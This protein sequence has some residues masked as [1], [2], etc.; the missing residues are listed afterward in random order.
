MNHSTKLLGPDDFFATHKFAEVLSP[1]VEPADDDTDR[2]L[3][4]QLHQLGFASERPSTVGKLQVLLA[5]FLMQATRLEGRKERK[6]EPMV[7]GIAHDE[8][9]W[10][11]RSS[12]GY[13][14][15]LRFREAL[16]EHA[17]IKHH[18]GATVNLFEGEGNCTGYLIADHVPAIA[19]GLHFQTTDKV[20]ATSTSSSNK[21]IEVEAV[22]ER[23]KALWAKWKHTPLM[24]G[25]QSMFIAPRRFNN[26]AL[27]RGGRFYGPWTSMRK[28][29]RLECTLDGKQV[30]EVDVSGMHLTLLCSIT[31]EIPFATRFKDAYECG[32]ENR[33]HV[34]AIINET[35]GAGTP[36]HY[37]IGGLAKASGLTQEQFTHIRKTFI[38]PKFRC[39]QGL[40]KGVLDGLALAYHESEIMLRVVEQSNLPIYILHDCLIC[41]KDEELTVG[42]LMQ[43]VYAQYC[44]EQ[45]WT[46]VAPAY[47]IERKGEEKH[48]I[49]GRRHP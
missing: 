27:T 15:A 35:I 40:K 20:Y 36:K 45:D 30:G 9:Y 16:V 44:R 8:A 7:I 11:K 49:S 17:W 42:K 25:N 28:V 24:Y 21:H 1:L 10:R 22:D 43:D 48:L 5:S 19:K 3:R 13:R 33:D 37:T 47:S 34:K 26:A 31:K 46:P 4:D 18:A 2:L 39:L 23:T 12:V 32:Y 41:Q 14:V 29:D 6:G 38:A